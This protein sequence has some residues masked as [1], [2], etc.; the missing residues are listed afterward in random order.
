MGTDECGFHR[1]ARRGRSQ[2]PDR[3]HRFAARP[4]RRRRLNPRAALAKGWGTADIES[5][6]GAMVGTV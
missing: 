2:Y 1:A 3:V 4:K 5:P 6:G